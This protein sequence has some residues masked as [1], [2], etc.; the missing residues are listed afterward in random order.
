MRILSFFSLFCCLV[1][2]SCEKETPVRYTSELDVEFDI[3]S[4][5]NTVETHYFIL[6]NV[7]V[8]YNQNARIY[9]T[10]TASIQNVISSRGLI[11]AKFVDVDFDFVSRIS[12]Y[13]VSR[14]NPSL[15]R[16]MFYLDQV[17]LTTGK[18]LRMLSSSTQL[19]DLFREEYIDLEIRINVR[20]FVPQPIRAR[21][22]FGY[23]VF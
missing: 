5:L 1:L 14:K 13:A 19:K 11:R 2:S 20:N 16:E 22:E 10:D 4:G 17:P 12:V 7:P 21:L 15:K 18:E 9:N 3:P 6:K 8:Y 23:A